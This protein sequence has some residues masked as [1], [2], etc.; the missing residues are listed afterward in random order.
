MNNSSDITSHKLSNYEKVMN[1]SSNG[2]F[3][4]C[5]YKFKSH[6]GCKLVIIIVKDIKANS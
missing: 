4:L 6:Y 2:T 3:T 1:Y 5:G